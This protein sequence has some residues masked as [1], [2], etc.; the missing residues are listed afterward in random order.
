MAHEAA[1]VAAGAKGPKLHGLLA[2][3]DDTEPLIAAAKAAHDAGYRKMDAYSPFPVEGLSEALGQRDMLVPILMMLAGLGGAVLG[4]AFLTFTTTIDYPMNVGGKPPVPW[5]QF[6]PITF[7]ITVLLAALT[8]VAGMIAINGLP[9][10]HHPLFARPEFSRATA[11]RFFL[12]IEATDPRFDRETTR[13][14]LERLHP[15]G[16]TEVEEEA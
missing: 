15:A 4:V 1:L 12:C 10:P 11:D 5:P 16:V 6:I 9:R 7:E 3:F 2:E 8:G 14:F 13:L